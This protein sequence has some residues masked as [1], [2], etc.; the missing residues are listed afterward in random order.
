MT[1]STFIFV[2][3]KHLFLVGLLLHEPPKDLAG[4][5]ACCVPP[6]ERIHVAVL[7][8][9]AHHSATWTPACHA[10]EVV[11]PVHGGRERLG[12][13]AAPGVGYVGPVLLFVIV[14][15]SVRAFNCLDNAWRKS[16]LKLAAWKVKVTQ[17]PLTLWTSAIPIGKAK[18]NC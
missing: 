2:E 13:V 18:G 11:D 12:V 5:K 10:L 16:K 7:P 17:D 4:L 1:P 14:V 3:L 6:R 8:S 9:A 15:D